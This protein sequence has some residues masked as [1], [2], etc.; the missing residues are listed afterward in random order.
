MARTRNKNIDI[1]KGIIIIL[2]I[3]GHGL[4]GWDYN[5]WDYRFPKESL[6]FGLWFNIYNL[7]ASLG[8]SV[9]F[10]ISGYLT[11]VNSVK[12]TNN[13]YE[14]RIFRF[15][16]PFIY[17]SVIYALSNYFIYGDEITLKG[18]ILGTGGI[19]LYFLVVLMQ[20]I[21]ITPLYFKCSKKNLFIVGCIIINIISGIVHQIHYLNT[22]SLFNNDMILCTCF[23]ASYFMGVH[24]K[25][26]ISIEKKI[27]SINWMW[28][29]LI[30]LIG[31][32]VRVANTYTVLK[33]T[34]F[35]IVA[36]SFVEL[37]GLIEALSFTIL[38]VKLLNISNNK[39]SCKPL[40]WLGERTMGIFLIHWLFENYLQ[41]WFNDHISMD[42][43]IIANVLLILSVLILCSICMYIWDIIKRRYRIVK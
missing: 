27:V 2:V 1:I 40:E 29:I 16:K 37:S 21:L 25:N 34:D 33:I 17:F 35:P 9:F 13:F 32:I 10:F 3:F 23:I 22:R 12:N 38:L 26:N 5:A 6:A 7:F 11:N 28:A 30:A 15:M 18:L 19:Q 41:R 24:I 39:L 20:L 8:V 4:G 31:M 36:I 42:Y 43:V 14:K